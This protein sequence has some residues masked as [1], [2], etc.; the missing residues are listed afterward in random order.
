MMESIQ[1]SLTDKRSR[2][3]PDNRTSQLIVVATDPEQAAVDT[4]VNQLDTPT[5][6]VLI[7]TRL[8][9]ISSNPTSTKGIDW[10][11]TLAAQNVTF[12]NNLQTGLSTLAPGVTGQPSAVSPLTGLLSATLAT[13][14]AIGSTA[15]KG[16]FGTQGFLNAD[17]V[18]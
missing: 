4:L 12:G 16:F 6:Q 8:V 18:H 15:S 2:V 9:G 3:I 7:E 10:S 17:G 11:G 5:K 1:G 14:A 13:P